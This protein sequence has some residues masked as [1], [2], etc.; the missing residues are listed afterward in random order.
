[1]SKK[2]YPQPVMA[3]FALRSARTVRGYKR[4]LYTLLLRWTSIYPV[5]VAFGRLWVPSQRP[6]TLT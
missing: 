6:T 3:D 4:K 5:S 2:S 1:L